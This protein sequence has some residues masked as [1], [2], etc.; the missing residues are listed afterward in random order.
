MAYNKVTKKYNN[1]FIETCKAGM[2]QFLIFLL[3]VYD[4]DLE[5]LNGLWE[6]ASH[7]DMSNELMKTN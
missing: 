6:P 7:E 2:D 3:Q 5:R 1:T 4:G